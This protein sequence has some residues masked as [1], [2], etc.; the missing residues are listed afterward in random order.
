MLFLFLPQWLADP[1][2][3]L[4]FVCICMSPQLTISGTLIVKN[5]WW[6]GYVI[7]LLAYTVSI[8]Q[9]L[10]HI[11]VIVSWLSLHSD[12]ITHNLKVTGMEALR[13]F[14]ETSTLRCSFSDLREGIGFWALPY[15]DLWSVCLKPNTA[16][17]AWFQSF[18]PTRHVLRLFYFPCINSKWCN[19]LVV[20]SISFYRPAKKKK[21][22][23]YRL[24]S[25]MSDTDR[26]AW[27][28][29]S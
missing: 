22:S 28:A 25:R 27:V 6:P 10:L 14:S 17:Q 1:T 15:P 12:W 20:G 5:I 29:F 2:F 16:I 24:F 21:I 26:T 7:G 4:T 18:R 9:D 8:S 13:D 23:F 11:N 3:V 19:A